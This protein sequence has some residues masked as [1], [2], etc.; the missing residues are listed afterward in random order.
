[1][2]EQDPVGLDTSF[3]GISIDPATWEDPKETFPGEII[4]SEFRLADERY[5]K[6]SLYRPEIT[7]DLPQW[8]VQVKRLDAIRHELDGAQTDVLY[9]SGPFDAIDM[10][11]FNVHVND[12]RG[13]LVPISSRYPKEWRVT[14]AYKNVFGTVQPTSVLVGKKAMFD[15]YQKLAVGTITISRVLEPVSVLPPEFAFDGEK[16]VFQARARQEDVPADGSTEGVPPSSEGAVTL[17]DEQTA[18]DLLPNLLAGQKVDDVAGIIAA[19][20]QNVRL[21]VVLNGIATQELLK[22]L[23]GQGAITIDAKSGVMGIA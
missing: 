7:E 6:E 22:E 23:Q 14:N 5:R 20:P 17:L 12:G 3:P 21:P 15:Y 8:N 18:I 13:G 11:K 1:M 16:V 19:L 10:K 2:P 9:G 4:I